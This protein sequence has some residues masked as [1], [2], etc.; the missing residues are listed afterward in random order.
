MNGLCAPTC[1]Q[2]LSHCGAIVYFGGNSQVPSVVQYGIHLPGKISCI[3][4]F[5]K[6]CEVSGNF[7]YRNDLNSF[8]KISTL[9]FESSRHFSGQKIHSFANSVLVI[10]LKLHVLSN[11]YE[12]GIRRK[13]KK[14]H[15]ALVI[16]ELILVCGIS[17]LIIYSSQFKQNTMKD[18][19]FFALGVL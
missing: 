19:L 9:T 15:V 8:I 6:S 10:S 13:T 3:E 5:N 7:N 12:W 11:F 1:C 17:L 18:S 16:K 4:V 14:M 2:W